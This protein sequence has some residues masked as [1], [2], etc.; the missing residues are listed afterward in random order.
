MNRILNIP[1]RLIIF[2][3]LLVTSSNSFAQEKTRVMEWV[4]TDQGTK[5]FIAFG[6][7]QQFSPT[8]IKAL[9]LI[10][11][12]VDGQTVQIGK[13]FFA[14]DNWIGKLTFKLKNISQ[15]PILSINLGL[16]L[17]EPHPSAGKYGF[18]FGYGKELGATFQGEKMQPIQPDEIVE[19]KF[20]ELQYHH[21]LEALSKPGLI[22]G[23]NKILVGNTTVYFDDG[24]VWLGGSLPV[25]Y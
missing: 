11:I 2:A 4:S 1:V 5:N 24:M 3:C 15:K 25:T 22:T 20:T 10:D 6:R 9:E 17:P 13:E 14:N 16:S 19:L 21:F 8:E 18:S 7:D 23:C 12:T